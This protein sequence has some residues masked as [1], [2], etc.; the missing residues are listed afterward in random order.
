VWIERQNRDQRTYYRVNRRHP[1]V[2]ALL[3]SPECTHDQ[4]VEVVRLVEET[5]P[6]NAI[7]GRYAVSELAQDAPFANDEST[8][9]ALLRRW[10]CNL[11]AAGLTDPEV[12]QALGKIDPF[13][14]HR[15]LVEA[16]PIDQL[17]CP[18]EG[19]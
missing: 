17:E 15:A 7:T 6:I 10:A 3:S 13:L 2:D 14:H 18:D 5:I 12:R 8:L 19:D 4:V 1:I 16:L 9:G 11:R